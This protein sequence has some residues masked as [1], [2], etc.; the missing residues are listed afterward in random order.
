MVAFGGVVVDHVEDDL[1]A[2]FV[3]AAHHHLELGDRAAGLP[4][5]RVLVVRGEEPECVVAPIV[6][7]SELQQ[8]L[9]VQELVHRHQLE[10]GDVE[11][12][13]VIDDRRVGQAGVCAPKSFGDAGMDPGQALDVGL[14]DDGLVVRGEWCAVER[15]VEEGVDH[16][17][18]HGLAER[19]DHRGS[20]GV[21]RVAFWANGVHVVREQRLPEGEVAVEGFSVRVEQQLARVTPVAG[22]RIEQ[23]VDSKPVA[24]AWAD[25]RQVGVPDVSVHLVEGDARLAAVVVDQA[26]VDLVGDLGEQRK[27]G[28][29]TVIGGPEWIGVA[30]PHG[31]QCGRG[32]VGVE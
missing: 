30:R 7:Q 22:R 20:T 11:R 16:H 27:V 5:R 17:A 29:G 14:V 2:G 3:Q 26:Q 28:A 19:V 21:C 4:V 13:E 23:P 12:L 8:P 31:R 10:R 15:P 24:L 25:V 9:V 1:D 32:T 18:G 6:S